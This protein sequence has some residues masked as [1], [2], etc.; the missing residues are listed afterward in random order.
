MSFVELTKLQADGTEEFLERACGDGPPLIRMAHGQKLRVRFKAQAGSWGR[1]AMHYE[2]QCGGP[3]AAGE[4]YLR[5]RLDEECSWLV[6]LPPGSKLSLRINHL[7]CP[8]DSLGT[9]KSPNGVQILNDDDQVLLAKMCPD[10]PA[11]LVVSASNVRILAKGV[12]LEAQYGN[13]ENSCSGNITSPRGSLSSPNYP[14]SYPANVEC[15]WRVEARSGNA[16]EVNFEAMDIVRSEHCNEDFLELR[17]GV[18][19]PLL[20]LYCSK[21]VPDSPMV[22]PSQLWIKFRSKPGNTAG[23]F[24]LRWSYGK[25]Y[26]LDRS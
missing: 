16:L 22:V 12:L 17:S 9:Q 4:G 13:L 8:K 19:G 7:E 14:A 6:T 21:E 11:N 15:V 20:G 1:F 18:Q 3:L 5:S 26:P 24:K 2:R 10:H 23:G 25:G